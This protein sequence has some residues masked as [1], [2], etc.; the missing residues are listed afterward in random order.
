MAVDKKH[1][2]HPDAHGY[3]GNFAM[4]MAITATLAEH[5]FPKCFFRM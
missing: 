4:H 3:Y 1:L 2:L 5:L